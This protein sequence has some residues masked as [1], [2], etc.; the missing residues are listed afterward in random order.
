M[1]VNPDP[2]VLI[3]PVEEWTIIIDAI[4]EKQPDIIKLRKTGHKFRTDR[5]NIVE[6]KGEHIGKSIDGLPYNI[7]KDA[8][9]IED[10]L[11]FYFNF[12]PENLK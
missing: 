11:D 8:E 10:L 6:W 2:S 4:Q 12:T 5:R 1:Q 9:L 7:E 3:R